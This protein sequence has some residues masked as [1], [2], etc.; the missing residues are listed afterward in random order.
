MKILLAVDGSDRSIAALD[1]LVAHV[2]WFREAP[3]V[4]LV[5]VHPPIPYAGAAARAGRETVEKYYDEES[6]KVLQ[7]AK[8]RLESKGIQA[9]AVALVGD[10]A[11]EIARYA[12]QHGKEL[13]A[14]GTHGRTGLSNLVLGSVATKVLAQS[15]VPVLLMR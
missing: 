5:N 14:M 2:R 13:I 9:D 7:P 4:T 8:A 1:Q 12:A 6:Q 10:P 15:K 3:S 11:E